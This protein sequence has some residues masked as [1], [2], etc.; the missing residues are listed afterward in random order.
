MGAPIM[1]IK[2]EKPACCCSAKAAAPS[3]N[4]A[5]TEGMVWIR[6]SDFTMGSD[7]FYREE[8]PARRATAPDFWIVAHPVM[9][10][11]FA[12]FVVVTGLVTIA[13]RQPEST[14]LRHVA[15][16]LTS[17]GLEEAKEHLRER[18]VDVRAEDHGN[19]LSV[20]VRDPDGNVVE[21][22]TYE[23]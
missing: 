11:Q 10:A 2:L 20:Y 16:M 7:V 17:V 19:A 1:D 3:M 14:G 4:A 6:G 12:V 18:G 13:E 15:F 21:L 5:R 8:R 22:T 23:R 9:I